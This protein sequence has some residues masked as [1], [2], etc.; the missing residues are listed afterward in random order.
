VTITLTLHDGRIASCARPYADAAYVVAAA[1][2]CAC[3][4]REPLQVA[5]GRTTTTL[6]GD[7][8]AR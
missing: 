5:G 4:P 3:E 1:L 2:R 6:G 8:D 7:R